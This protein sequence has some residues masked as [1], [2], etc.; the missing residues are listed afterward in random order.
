[1]SGQEG[2]VLFAETFQ[3]FQLAGNVHGAVAVIAYIKRYNA[4]GVAGYQECILLLVVEGKGKDAGEVLQKVD[5]FLALEGQNHLAVAACMK[6]ILTGIA[7]ADF[8]MIVD[9]TVHG[10]DL[11]LVGAVERLAAT[12]GVNDRESLMCQDGRAATVDSTPVRS[13]VTDF[14]THT[15]RLLSQL[16]RLLLDIKYGYNSTPIGT[17]LIQI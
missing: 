14:L 13:A 2:F 9:L 10:Q 15:Q 11:L 4:N 5:A 8:L 1:M 17:V 16:L 3:G 6:V 12:F 7:S